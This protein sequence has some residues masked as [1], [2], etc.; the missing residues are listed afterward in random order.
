VTDGFLAE[1]Q[2]WSVVPSRRAIMFVTCLSALLIAGFVWPLL[3]AVAL[4]LDVVLLGL[5]LVD[6]ALARGARLTGRREAPRAMWLGAPGSV[7]LY[8]QNDGPSPLR[9]RLRELLAPQLVADPVDDEVIV[10]PGRSERRVDVVPRARGDASID[11]AAA[12]VLGPLGLAWAGFSL[13]AQAS[14]RVLPRVHLGDARELSL[15]RP[16]DRRAGHA[17]SNRQGPSDELRALRD[18]VSGDPWRTIDW[19]ASA[20]RDRPVTR[21]TAW[22]H[23]QDVVLLLDCGRSMATRDGDVSKQDHGLEACLR[24]L[25][26]A[27]ERG[28]GV[29]LVLFSRAVRKVVQLQRGRADLR[30]VWDAVYAEHA[31]LDEP[32]YRAAARWVDQHAPRDALVLMITSV[33]DPVRADAITSAMVMM[34]RR[35]RAVLVDLEDPAL[36]ELARTPPEDATA[37]FAMTQA[38]TILEGN[39][40]MAR[41]LGARGVD[42]LHV[43]APDLTERV[44]Q[45]YLSHRRSA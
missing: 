15:R 30:S 3:G 10:P 2:R 42:T 7:G 39:R 34:A 33:L 41:A 22:A 18:Y 35:R 9:V 17:R 27:R 20:R 19:K 23:H 1:P 32:D 5:V 44:V 36:L 40:Q 31:D 37:A 28:D 29:S 45:R 4:G 6:G 12:R 14:V 13:G 16:I 24:L 38:R 8:L 25:R 21:E 26:L 11:P 43:A